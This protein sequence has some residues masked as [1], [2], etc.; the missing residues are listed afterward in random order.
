MYPPHVRMPQM[1]NL[2]RPLEGLLT[3]MAAQQL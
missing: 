2:N 3:S 1:R